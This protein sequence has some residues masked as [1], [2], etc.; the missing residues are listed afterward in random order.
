MTVRGGRFLIG[1]NVVS[2][3]KIKRHGGISFSTPVTSD[4]TR[5]YVRVRFVNMYWARFILNFATKIGLF[6]IESLY[7]FTVLK[8]YVKKCAINNI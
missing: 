2:K 1:G 4:L 6:V 3:L 7:K 8:L 5:L